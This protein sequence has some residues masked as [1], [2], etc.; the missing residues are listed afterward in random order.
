MPMSVG[1]HRKQ[2]PICGGEPHNDKEEKVDYYLIYEAERPKTPADVRAESER[3]GEVALWLSQCL[4]RAQR[5]FVV[6]GQSAYRTVVRTASRLRARGAWSRPGTLKLAKPSNAS[7]SPINKPTGLPGT[8][9]G[10]A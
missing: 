3:A 6:L 7:C 2:M 8:F 1:Q 4:R 5:P 10:R 9:A